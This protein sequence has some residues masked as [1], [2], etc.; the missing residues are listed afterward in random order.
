MKDRDMPPKNA[1]YDA[2]ENGSMKMG[3]MQ[4]MVQSSNAS[5]LKGLC[6]F[7]GMRESRPKNSPAQKT[8]DRLPFLIA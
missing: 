3:L 1:S 8:D 6:V 4:P 2:P 5:H 7:C